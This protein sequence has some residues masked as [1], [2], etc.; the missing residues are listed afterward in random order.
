MAVLTNVTEVIN[1]VV[2]GLKLEQ[3]KEYKYLRSKVTSDD[4]NEKD[5][6]TRRG[7]AKGASWKQ[8]DLMRRVVTA[9]HQIKEGT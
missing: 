5:V 3:V 2:K 4:D 9:N 8:K 7:M 6:K 1:F